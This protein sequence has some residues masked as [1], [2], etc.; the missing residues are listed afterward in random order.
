MSVKVQ[1]AMKFCG[2]GCRSINGRE[3]LGWSTN[4]LFNKSTEGSLSDESGTLKQT[5]HACVEITIKLPL[6]NDFALENKINKRNV[7]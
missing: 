5:D 2:R 6:C 3:C 4:P 1:Q 7:R